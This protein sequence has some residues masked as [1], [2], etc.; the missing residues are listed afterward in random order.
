VV[1]LGRV[2]HNK[3]FDLLLDAFAE[4]HLRVSDV[5][6]VI[7]G[8]GAARGALQEQARR[9][10]LSD[11][12]WFPGQL[13]RA[14]V[15][16]LLRGAEVFVMPSRVEPFGIVIL[17]AWRA[18]CP[19]VASSVGGAP[20][21]VRHEVDGLVV[22]PRDTSALASAIGHILQSGSLAEKLAA[23]GSRRVREFDWSYVADQYR[24]IYERVVTG[25]RASPT[26]SPPPSPNSVR[27]PVL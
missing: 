27:D 2:V 9:L 26:S 7:G 18:G 22:D 11:R 10:G 3:G 5:G 16:A 20:E 6:L 19:V 25:G 8:V 1:C 15:G 23:N 14:A 12:V 17:E 4:L 13:D 21:F 24:T